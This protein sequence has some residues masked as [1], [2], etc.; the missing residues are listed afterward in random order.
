M[1]CVSYMKYYLI[2]Y[3]GLDHCR[4][5]YSWGSWNQSPMDT[6]KQVYTKFS[7]DYHQTQEAQEVQSCNVLPL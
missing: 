1:I 3:K 5:W 7:V 2:L 4:F 6:K